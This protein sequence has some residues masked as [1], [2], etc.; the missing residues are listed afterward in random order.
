MDQS[1]HIFIDNYIF[2]NILN[3][4]EILGKLYLNVLKIKESGQLNFLIISIENN[5]NFT[6]K[7]ERCFLKKSV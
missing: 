7:V 5:E 3:S 1:H 6:E 2:R 4:W